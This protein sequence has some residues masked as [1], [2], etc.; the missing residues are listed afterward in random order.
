MKIP[1]TFILIKGQPKA[2]Q[3]ETFG[4]DDNGVYNV[5]FKSSPNIYHYKGSDVVWIKDCKWHDHLHCKVYIGGTEQKNVEDIRSFEQGAKTHWR[6][7]FSNGYV[8]DYLDGS[9]DVVES[10]L[11]DGVAENS[12]EYLKRVAKTNEL[13]KDEEH[14]GILPALYEE[15]DFIDKSLA[16]AS[17]LNSEEYKV[18]TSKAPALIFP[19]GCNSRQEKTVTAAFTNQIRVI[20]GPPGTGKNLKPLRPAHLLRYLQ[21]SCNSSMRQYALITSPVM[22]RLA[23][24]ASRYLF[25]ASRIESC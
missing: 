7:T 2:H 19:F 25:T 5:K 12:F 21:V 23:P 9:V 3:I 4:L 16:A 17:Y 20:Q 1:H 24:H 18:K 14:G 6:I 11:V 10:C 15:I 13:G 22:E 8:K